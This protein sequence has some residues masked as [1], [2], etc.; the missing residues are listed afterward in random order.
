M[1]VLSYSIL[2]MLFHIQHKVFGRK[3]STRIG[4]FGKEKL[5]YF[6]FISVFILPHTLLHQDAVTPSLHNSQSPLNLRVTAPSFPIRK[7]QA[8]KAGQGS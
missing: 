3:K 1:L 8:S 4:H 2:Y 6:L 5:F 7:E